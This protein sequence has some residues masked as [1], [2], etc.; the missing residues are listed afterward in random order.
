MKF[1]TNRTLML[2]DDSSH[3]WIILSTLTSLLIYLEA[4]HLHQ[5]DGQTKDPCSSPVAR[6]DMTGCMFIF[7]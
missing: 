7:P 5:I 2:E 1:N 3:S 4:K 6:G